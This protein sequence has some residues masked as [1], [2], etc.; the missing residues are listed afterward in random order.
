MLLVVVPALTPQLSPWRTM[1]AATT[2]ARP[3]RMDLSDSVYD[4]PDKAPTRSVTLLDEFSFDTEITPSDRL[5][6]VKFFA[7]GCQQCRSIASEYDRVARLFAD[8]AAFYEVDLR[9][10]KTVFRNEQVLLTPT[11][12]FYLGQAGCVERFVLG[13]TNRQEL[14]NRLEAILQPENLEQLRILDR[15]ALSSIVRLK[16]LLGAVQAVN[17]APEYL[18]AQDVQWLTAQQKSEIKIL[19]QWLDRNGANRRPSRKFATGGWVPTSQPMDGLVNTSTRAGY[20]LRLC[21]LHSHPS[22]HIQC[23]RHCIYC[24]AICRCMQVMGSS[25]RTRWAQP[26]R[27]CRRAS[28]TTAAWHSSLRNFCRPW[29]MRTATPAPTPSTRT[30]FFG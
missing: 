24:G 30:L 17:S 3:P 29:S 28:A 8:R 23:H 14:S 5:S 4:A 15:T 16:E 2:P 11:I 19:F 9:R 18:K 6:V 12:H 1:H 25:T 13:F 10:A 20:A 22:S 21:H 7:P 26:A 27:C